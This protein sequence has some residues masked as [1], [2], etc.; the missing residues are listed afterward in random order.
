MKSQ[1]SCILFS[2]V[3]AACGGESKTAAPTP[4][5]PSPVVEPVKPAAVV[6]AP[7]V[8]PVVPPVV[9]PAVVEH[10]V[11]TKYADAVEQ[12]K[13]LAGKGD[14]VAAREMFE[15][16]IKLDAKKAEPHI[17]LARLY[18]TTGD[19]GPAVIA[20][21][22]GV[23]LA[24]ESSQAWNTL[25]RAELA[26]FDYDKAIEAFAKSTQINPDNVWAWNNLGF[27]QLQLKHYHEAVD[28]LV[29]A[30]TRKGAEG[31]MFNNLG[32]AYE[33]LDMLDDARNAFGK[34][35]EL[36]STSAVASRK[37]LEGVKTIVVTATKLDSEK[38]DGVVHAKDTKVVPEAAKTY[39]PREEMPEPP[40][41]EPAKDEVDD[42]ASDASPDVEQAK[43]ASM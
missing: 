43:P 6:E 7:K 4:V 12:G 9:T 11:P 32:T 35:G 42:A 31:Y 26:R 3:V 36:G 27:A 18:I 2:L 38:A 33:Q 24:P 29:E 20:A 19:R 8:V 34:G 5:A 39:E 40:A 23:K 14:H 30:T 25:G 1:V 22:R 15:A 28:A 13:Q 10:P 21:K 17:E 41:V 37:R 16:A